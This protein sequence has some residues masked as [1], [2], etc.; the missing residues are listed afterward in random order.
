MPLPRPHPY[1]SAPHS[2][3]LDPPLLE[4]DCV[5]CLFVCNE[6]KCNVHKPYVVEGSAVVPLDKAMTSS[7]RLSIVP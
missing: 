3:F 4:C 7:Y 5:F 6:C 2:K 1:L